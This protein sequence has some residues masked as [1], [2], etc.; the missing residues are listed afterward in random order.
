VLRLVAV[1]AVS[2]FVDNTLLREAVEREM[3]KPEGP[4][5][6]TICH[7]LGWT[8][9]KKSRPNPSPDTTRLR[10]R[11]GHATQRMGNGAQGKSKRVQYDVAVRICEA[12]GIDPVDVGL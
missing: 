7:R 11:L 9:A 4:T 3:A 12:A 8:N 2:D 1:G 10:R 5:L 6:A